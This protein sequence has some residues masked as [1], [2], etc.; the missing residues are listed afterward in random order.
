[1]CYRVPAT[2]SAE[3]PETILKICK[4]EAINAIIPLLD[5]DISVFCSNREMFEREGIKLL[6]SPD[7]SIDIALD[8]L[9]TAR[10]LDKLGLPCPR[11][12]I[13]SDWA[14]CLDTIVLPS[15]NKASIS[16]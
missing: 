1:M 4:K 15:I 11:T 13:A 9:A 16:R 5:L 6:L 2:I 12:I 10:F 7:A 3:Y 14:K 8:K